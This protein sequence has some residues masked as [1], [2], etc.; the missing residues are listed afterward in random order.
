MGLSA[1]GTP[2]P[3]FFASSPPTRLRRYIRTFRL[4]RI[5]NRID[6]LGHMNEIQM[7]GDLAEADVSKLGMDELR[8]ALKASLT[9]IRQLKSELQ[10][11]KNGRP[12]MEPQGGFRGPG[13]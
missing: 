8:R 4:W 9:E 1:R 6:R 2:V 5:F 11:L 3:P 12:S 13:A 10:Q 7:L